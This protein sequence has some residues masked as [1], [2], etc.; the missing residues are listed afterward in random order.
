MVG[1]LKQSMAITVYNTLTKKKEVFTP[2]TSG[3][4]K[5]Y[6]CGPTVYDLLH[7]GNFRG[8]VFYNLV[9]NWLEK[10]G[11]KVT[12]AYNYTDVDDKIINRALREKVESHEISEKYIAEFKKDFQKLDLRP[13]DLNP[14]VTDYMPA[15]IKMI[16]RLVETAK[17]YVVEG[18]VLYSINS[19]SEYGKLSGRNKD[20]LQAG[21]RVEIDPK[22]KDPMDFALWKPAKPGEPSWDSPWGPGRPGWHI[23]CSAMNYEV[24]G[25]QIDIHG[26]GMD[27]IFPH[28]ENEIAQ[29]EG[30][31]H[32]PFAK[33]WLHHNMLNFSGQKM[34]KSVGNIMTLREFLE[35]HHPEIYKY[36]ILSSHYRSICEFSPESIDRAIHGLARIYSALALATEHVESL[37]QEVSEKNLEPKWVEAF[38]SAQKEIQSSLDDDFNT[39]EVFAS[40]FTLIRQFN[41]QVRPGQKASAQSAAKAWKLF[42]FVK[43]QGSLM[44]LFQQEPKTFLK[45]LD[46][47][48]LKKMNLERPKVDALV[49]ERQSARVNKDYKRSDELRDQ[50]LKMGIAVCDTPQG[51]TWEVQK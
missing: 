40:F 17:A 8:P 37:G 38:S 34:S 24:F 35:N 4:V 20:E 28:H 9:R 33:Y 42:D 45:E 31:T 13:H 23:E 49:N 43:S 46:D 16:A 25:E 41:A 1:G 30:C 15:I 32:K 22:K 6:C 11:Y 29:S 51:T 10:S 18:E 50:L 36:M 47:M 44:A 48:L 26:G 19:F 27:L 39:P 2:L 12:Y 3:E 7:V 21:Q 5:M 14:K